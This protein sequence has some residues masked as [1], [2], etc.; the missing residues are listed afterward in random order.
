MQLLKTRLQNREIL[1]GAWTS[2]PHPS[3]TEMFC[4]ILKPDFVGIDIEHTTVGLE[5]VQQ[6]ITAGQSCGVAMFPRVASHNGEQIRRVLDAGADGVIVPQ[7]HS[8]KD[9][10][11]I[12]QWMK[13]PP[14]GKRGFGVS[15]AQGYGGQFEKY[16]ERW[17]NEAVF[18]P[19]IESI[20]GVENV[21]SILDSE[22]VD[23]V[24]IGP[25]DISGSLGVPG[26]LNDP[27]VLNACQRV[28]EACQRRKK[29]CGNQIVEPSPE[30]LKSAIEQGYTFSILSSDLFLI[31]KWSEKM[32]EIMKQIRKI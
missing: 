4:S 1:F 27:K 14:V 5:T 26:K 6:I 21:D 11:Q 10:D 8:R 20:E 18:I 32:H 15:R 19:Q 9:V 31:W 30:N 2:V 17:N 3:V 16:I 7:V 28:V 12:I 13:Y 24:M 29:S 23:G 25:Y 22:H